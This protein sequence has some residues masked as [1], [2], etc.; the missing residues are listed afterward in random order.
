MS[1]GKEIEAEI[2][3]KGDEIRQLKTDG[4]SKDD[5]KP[6]IDELVSLKEQYKECTGQDYTPPGGGKDK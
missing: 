5:L 1:D 4:A 2:V 3:A 6:H